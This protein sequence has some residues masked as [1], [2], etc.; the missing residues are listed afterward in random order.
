[1]TTTATYN[2][3]AWLG[4]YPAH[5]ENVPVWAL[6][7]DNKIKNEY[8]NETNVLSLSYGNII[9]RDVES[10]MGLLPESFD[11]YQIVK[12]GNIILRLT[13]LQN[14]KKSLR[15]GL[16]KENG[17]ITSAYTGL[18]LKYKNCVIDYFYYALHTLD[19]MKYFYSLG[20][21]V[22][23]SIGYRELK[24]LKLPVPPVE[25]QNKIVEYIKTQSQKINHFIAK[26]QQFS[27]P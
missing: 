20:G 2:K 23:Q 14:D 4:N 12:A 22:R 17:I 10:N 26:K 5:W 24:W 9:K 3:S 18:V 16:A 6:F 8:S 27:V 21:G 1:M 13:D 25:E 19:L 15:V 11:T 7:N